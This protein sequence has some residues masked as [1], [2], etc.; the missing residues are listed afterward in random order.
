MMRSRLRDNLP[1][2]AAS[3]LLHLGAGGLLFAFS[4]ATEDP[5]GLTEPPGLTVGIAWMPEVAPLAEEGGAGMGAPAPATEKAVVE[6]VEAPPPARSAEAESIPAEPEPDFFAPL[7]SEFDTAPELTPAPIAEQ[8]PAPAI[9]RQRPMPPGRPDVAATRPAPP[10]EEA[11]QEAVQKPAK[12][13]FQTAMA[14]TSPEN[15]ASP[16]A[17]G[18]VAQPSRSA[19]GPTGQ[20]PTGQ[21]PTNQS[22]Q[23][24]Q[25]NYIA[26]LRSWL[27]RHKRYPGMARRRGEEGIVMLS[28]D[29]DRHG[30]LLSRRVLRSSGH[31]DLDAAA[32][33]MLERASPLPPFPA[34]LGES[35]LSLVLPVAFSLR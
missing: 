7:P 30:R 27:E 29:L 9:P 31:Q 24:G 25:Q 11:Q 3:C 8:R 20:T 16:G 22:G 4:L 18:P 26:Q 19:T 12:P 35:R 34:D 28:L 1:F 23:A 17:P 32:L 2:L 5:P 15:S 13:P 6:N 10:Q 33:A 21:T 14:A